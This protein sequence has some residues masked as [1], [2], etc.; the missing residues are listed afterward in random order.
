MR[1]TA[2]V[3]RCYA[4][5]MTDLQD[6]L[7][8]SADG[9]RS[10]IARACNITPQAVYQWTEVPPQHVLTVEKMTGISRHFLRPDIFGKA[11]AE[12]PA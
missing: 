1:L 12:T 6:L 9:T 3:S 11:S 4:A 7:N 8:K 10:D 2:R 5:V